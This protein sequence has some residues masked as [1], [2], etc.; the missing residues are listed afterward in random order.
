MYFIRQD[1]ILLLHTEIIFIFNQ[2][3]ITLLLFILILKFAIYG[4]GCIKN[5]KTKGFYPLHKNHPINAIHH[6]SS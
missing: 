6:F 3:K 4:I 5:V 1:F 2:K